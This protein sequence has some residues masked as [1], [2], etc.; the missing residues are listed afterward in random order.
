MK[1]GP[2]QHL[3]KA[4][5]KHIKALRW[6]SNTWALSLRSDFSPRVTA[7][8]VGVMYFKGIEM[9]FI[10]VFFMLLIVC[11]C[12]SAPTAS[13]KAECG[14]IAHK[15]TSNK[16][17]TDNRAYDSCKNSYQVK[18]QD[19]QQKKGTIFLFDALLSIFGGDDI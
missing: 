1:F 4:H 11:A 5:N 16:V 9:K 17:Y 12:S 10:A 3:V 19:A 13:Q 18:N 6:D 2:N 14:E 15:N 8:Y 7:P